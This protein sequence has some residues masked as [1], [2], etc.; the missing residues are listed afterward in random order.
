[1]TAT[2][3]EPISELDEPDVE[4]E[5]TTSE[6]SEP[7]DP[8]KIRVRSQQP[9]V[10][11]L[12]RRV[13]ND[14]L[15]LYPDFQRLAGIW[16]QRTQSRLIESILLGIPLPAFYFDATDPDR[17]IVVDGLQRLTAL[18]R[19][20]L[21]D[22]HLAR[23]ELQ[24]LRLEDLEFLKE[25]EGKSLNDL[26]RRYQ[27]QIE[28]AQLT[29]YLIE[30]GTPEELK[31]NIFR[32]INTGGLPLS[33]QEIR[34]ALNQGKA[35][36]LLKTLAK[37]QAFIE[38]T[39][40]GISGKRMAD[41]ECVLRFI[42]FSLSPPESYIKRDFDFF[43]SE[44]M[45]KLNH[46]EDAEL[47]ALAQRFERAMRGAR[48][49][50]DD[51]AFRKRYKKGAARLF[52]NKALF[53]AWSVNLDRLGDEELEVL[54]SRRKALKAGFIKLMQDRD[55]DRSISQGTGDSAKVHLRFSSIRQLIDEALRCQG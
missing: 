13:E 47:K 37:S 27:R 31:F 8:S 30:E 19:F 43:L 29:A 38:A 21:E 39:A 46:L 48:E 51:D 52:I 36:E 4:A 34:H 14:E 10:Y 35:S 12:I 3:D 11:H 50:F 22:E 20:M 15:D 18:A 33:A 24:P 45:K 32:R 26:P 7:Y 44:Q 9:A 2:Y 55:F 49:L 28:E 41:R 25:L 53:E 40:G 54:R 16:K 23:L 17:W 5:D 6:I 42:A 1:M